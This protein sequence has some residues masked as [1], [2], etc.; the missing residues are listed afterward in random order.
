MTFKTSVNIRFDIGKEEFINR[1][2][3]T[4]SHTEAL[5]GLLDGFVGSGN[6]SH[7]IVGAYGTGK[8]LLA[9]VVSTLMSNQSKCI[10]KLSNKFRHFDDEI[11]EKIQQVSGTEKKYLPIALSGN[12]GR[13][14]KS[15]IKALLQALRN[16]GVEII[17]P[18]V[19]HK[20]IETIT[21]WKESFPQTF[22]QFKALAEE[23]NF[24]LEGFQAKIVEE[25]EG[26][27]E[28]FQRIYPRLT[29]GAQ[30]EMDYS[31]NF[32]FKI[33]LLLKA[34]SEHKKVLII[35][36]DEFGRFLQGLPSDLMNETMQDIQDLAEIAD[37]ETSLHFMLITHKN[38]RQYFVGYND[39]IAKE[40]Q[41]VEKRL[42]QYNISSDQATFLKIAQVILTENL[43]HKPCIDPKLIPGMTKG[44]QTF[45]MF[46]ILN[47]EDRQRVIIESL[48]PVHPATVYLLPKLSSVFG[49]NERT[50]FT[51]LESNETGGL[52]NHISKT[53][54]YYLPYKLFDYFFTSMEDTEISG[55]VSEEFVLYRKALT[56]VNTKEVDLD[57]AESI[58]KLIS[59]W[60]ICNLSIHQK[61]TTDF[62]QFALILEDDV[63]AF[64]LKKLT[65]AKAI[66]FNPLTNDWEIHTGSIVDLQ[67]KIEKQ[68]KSYV[69]SPEVVCKV[70]LSD[71]KAKY[72]FPNYFNDEHEMTRF[73]KVTLVLES[74]LKH[75]N[76]FRLKNSRYDMNIYYIIAENSSPKK[77]LEYISN[78]QSSTKEV[79]VVH[80]QTV[81]VIKSHLINAAILKEFM[82]DK[83][84]LAE[85]KGIL[86]EIKILQSE[87]AFAIAKYINKLQRLDKD[88]LWYHVDGAQQPQSE[89]EISTWLSRICERLYPQ[90]PKIVNDSFN[91][92]NLSSQQKA[93]SK[94][95]ID[96]I[97]EHPKEEQFG[98][99][100]TGPAYAIYAAVFK[101]NEH[102]EENIHMMDYENIIYQPYAMLRQEI[103]TL[104]ERKPT[105]SF[106]DLIRIFTASPYG[107]RL[108]VVP[109]LLVALL[110]DRWSEFMLYRNDIF[111]PGINGEKLYE[112]LEE[113]GAENYRY[114]Y[115]KIA[116][117]HLK[118]YNQLDS[119]FADFTEERLEGQNVSRLIQTC[120]TLV[121][122]LRS[123]PRYIQITRQVSLEFETLRTLIK[124][125][126]VKP[127]QSLNNLYDTFGYNIEALHSVKEYAETLI[128]IKRQQAYEEFK[129]V[130]SLTSKVQ[131]I[132]WLQQ[133]ESFK[134][135]NDLVKAL[136]SSQDNNEWFNE[137]LELFTGVRFEDWSDKTFDKFVGELEDSIRELTEVLLDE[138]VANQSNIVSIKIGNQTKTIAKTEF[139]VK[140]KT[141]YSNIDRILKN[142]GRNI[143]K[144][145]IEYMILLLMQDYV[146]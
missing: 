120:G 73:A 139:S 114:T 39:E 79:F 76:Q 72:F 26:S 28:W 9:T 32:L 117:N 11:A 145:E 126:E 108:P 23:A 22:E 105:G 67:Q 45:P 64:T 140:S 82:A 142:A 41:R 19:A 20:I 121:K 95:V 100:G 87:T 7:I 123:L 8:S 77:I 143:P 48:Y 110:R 31:D 50:L 5:N 127:Q 63:L 69:L 85:D 35:I 47:V 112:I 51:F 119:V 88:L 17:L 46:P 111:V 1:Y 104:L 107:I 65:D 27:I 137:F 34:A 68:K 94:Q 78:K 12:E 58:L 135:T 86:E 98:I 116:D 29:S 3:P 128:D 4:P 96:A 75:L 42:R 37:R 36:Y 49:Q 74:Q 55:S 57:V 90:T 92:M 62:I 54:D 113:E 136:N 18:G 115:E 13:F 52:Q 84:L 10:E 134:K 131:L 106:A 24:E 132:T 66:R 93:G 144:N 129:R 138:E 80:P 81:K 43:E 109:L 21:L 70:L 133:Y 33:E 89:K 125:T 56:R 99:S 38:L 103:L 16:E 122:W 53:N 30:F 61:L 6:R 91:R 118:F 141:V 15:I 60:K 40:F 44:I 146:E 97:L 102:F 25:D 14:R 83:N 130:T 124:Q 2:I 59:I 101:N 71:F